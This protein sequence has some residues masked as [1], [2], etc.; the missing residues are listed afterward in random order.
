MI[1]Y[2]FSNKL[3][4]QLCIVENKMFVEMFCKMSDPIRYVNKVAANN[5]VE[6]KLEN[7]NLNFVCVEMMQF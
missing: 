4:K 2:V 3:L 1:V 5:F 7:L 6:T